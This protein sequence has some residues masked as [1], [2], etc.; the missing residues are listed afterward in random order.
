MVAIILLKSPSSD[1]AGAAIIFM[2]PPNSDDATVAIILSNL[3]TA[4]ANN[5]NL[6]QNLLEPFDIS[7][8]SLYNLA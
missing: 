5:L 2:E 7:A 4:A 3:R 1:N 8:I 6:K